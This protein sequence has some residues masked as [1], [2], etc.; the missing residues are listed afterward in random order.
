M[1]SEKKQLRILLAD[2]HAVLRR[3]AREILESHRGWRVVGEAGTGREAVTKAKRLK[4]DVAIID[5]SMPDLDGLQVTHQ[6]REAVPTVEVLVFTM[7]ESEYMVRCAIHAGAS[8]FLLKSD[9][10][11]GLVKAVKA[12][13]NSKLFLPPRMGHTESSESVIEDTNSNPS[14]RSEALPTPRQFE[15]IRLLAL[16]RAN[17]EIASE[18]GIAVRTVE[19]H[20]AKIMLKLGIHSAIQLVH[21]AIRNKLILVTGISS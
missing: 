9:L 12:L 8:G 2:D 3:G 20:R 16:G 17:K 18:L 21:Y 7:H 11:K 14:S 19:T 13:S 5:I 4:P 15:I 10:T 1:I 6:I